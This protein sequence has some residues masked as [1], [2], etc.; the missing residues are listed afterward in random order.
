MTLQ[1]GLVVLRV[2]RLHFQH[3]ARLG[4]G[5]G[6]FRVGQDQ[7]LAA[8]GTQHSLPTHVLHQL[9]GNS[10]ENGANV[11][12]IA[13]STHSMIYLRTKGHLKRST[14]AQISAS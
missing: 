11:S 10:E 13:L 4:E 5:G 14:M 6:A 7:R 2:P 12:F 3:V 1:H 9:R 8:E